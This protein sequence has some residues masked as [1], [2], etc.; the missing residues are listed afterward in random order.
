MYKW[1]VYTPFRGQL[2]AASHYE[3][4]HV[5]IIF[6]QLRQGCYFIIYPF[7]LGADKQM[8]KATDC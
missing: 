6:I 7:F 4:K 1:P 3:D 5:A 2:E 8:D